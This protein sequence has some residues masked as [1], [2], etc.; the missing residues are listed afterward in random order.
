MDTSL[1]FVLTGIALI[2]LGV[3]PFAKEAARIC[4]AAAAVLGIIVLIGGV[5]KL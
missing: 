4:H 1:L 2:L 5:I 3:A